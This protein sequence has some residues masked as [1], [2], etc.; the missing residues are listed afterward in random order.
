MNATM[1][2]SA[3]PA[4]AAKKTYSEGFNRISIEVKRKV[5]GELNA[6]QSGNDTAFVDI[7]KFP[8]SAKKAIDN[9][10]FVGSAAGIPD[11]FDT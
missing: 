5:I 4:K 10:A 8:V 1:T 3:K 11:D 6:S 2:Q 9:A 7:T